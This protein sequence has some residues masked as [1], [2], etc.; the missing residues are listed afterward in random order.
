VK[1]EAALKNVEE[2][3][4]NLEVGHLGIPAAGMLKVTQPTWFGIQFV[5]SYYVVDNRNH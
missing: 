5:L 2:V 1:L 4:N 3:L